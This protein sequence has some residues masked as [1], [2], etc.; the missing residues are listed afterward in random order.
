MTSCSSCSRSTTGSRPLDPAQVRE[1]AGVL[2]A[3]VP[4]DHPAVLLAVGAERPVVLAQ[5]HPVDRRAGRADGGPAV[6]NLP[7]EVAQ[8][9]ELGPQVVVH[10]DEVL[11]RRLLLR[12]VVEP[13]WHGKRRPRALVPRRLVTE[14]R[15]VVRCGVDIEPRVALRC[16][17]ARRHDVAGRRGGR[18]GLG[19][20]TAASAGVHEVPDTGCHLLAEPAHVVHVVAAEDER[21][22]S[23][24]ESQLGQLFGPV[25]GS[26]REAAAASAAAGAAEGAEDVVQAADR[27]GS[28][29]AS[30]AAVSMASFISGRASGSA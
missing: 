5:R 20:G 16:R 21:A 19:G 11:R 12:G 2:E 14:P 24:V 23:L 9:G 15:P 6:P 22:H 25:L 8:T 13:G 30:R 7:D 27:A 28:R 17:G 10:V 4:G 3:V 26:A 29:S 1:Q 18:R